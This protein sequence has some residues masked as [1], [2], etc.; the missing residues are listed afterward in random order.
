MKRGSRK[1]LTIRVPV[2]VI[3]AVPPEFEVYITAKAASDLLALEAEKIWHQV[4]QAQAKS[5]K[6]KVRR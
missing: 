5:K 4:F 2:P 3:M 1:T 6:A